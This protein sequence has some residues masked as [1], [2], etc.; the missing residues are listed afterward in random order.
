MT[1]LLSHSWILQRDGRQRSRDFRAAIAQPWNLLL[2]GPDPH[3]GWSAP[4]LRIWPGA[5]PAMRLGS[6]LP[7]APAAALPAGVPAL[8][9]CCTVCRHW[10][11][12]MVNQ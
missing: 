5:V 11:A 9:A 7:A 4:D 3:S 10:A 2:L 12:P 1:S 8:T 6:A